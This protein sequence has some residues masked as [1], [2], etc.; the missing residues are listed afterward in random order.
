MYIDCFLLWMSPCYFVIYGEREGLNKAWL[1]EA[2]D[3]WL[4]EDFVSIIP[5]DHRTWSNVIKSPNPV[6]LKVR[7]EDSSIATSP[8]GLPWW[9][10]RKESVCN[11][12]DLGKIPG[13]G[14]SHGEGDGYS[15]TLVWRIPQSEEPGRL[16]PM[17]SQRVGLDWVT[18][19][20]H[21]INLGSFF[22]KFTTLHFSS[23]R[24]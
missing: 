4:L 21:I 22:N 13:L 7:K 14:R 3:A 8:K 1:I 15:S 18:K 6:A 19:C 10:K 9:L 2:L 20:R 23:P 24:L 5:Q 11:A 16:Q 17:G 12:G